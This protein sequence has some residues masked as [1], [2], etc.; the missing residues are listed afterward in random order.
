MPGLCGAGDRTQDLTYARQALYQ[1]SNILSSQ[2]LLIPPSSF[3]QII[4]GVGAFLKLSP[5]FVTLEEAV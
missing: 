5:N 2:C 1:L 4:S 3:L